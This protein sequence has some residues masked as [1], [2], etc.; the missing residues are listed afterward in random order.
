MS[1]IRDKNGD[2]IKE[3]DTVVT[4]M[5]GGK[6]E[7]AVHIPFQFAAHL[8]DAKSEIYRSRGSSRRGK[9]PSR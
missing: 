8:Q 5:R 7:G 2:R 3:G 6:R 1:N 9:K 4:K